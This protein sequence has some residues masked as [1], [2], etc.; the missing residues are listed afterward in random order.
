MTKIY[1]KTLLAKKNAG[2]TLIELLVVVLIIGI[3]S[4]VALPQY[5][6][7]VQKTRLMNYYQMAQGIRRAQEMYYLA[8][9]KYTTKLKDLDVDYSQTC[10][11]RENDGQVLDCPFA[12]IRNVTGGNPVPAANRVVIYFHPKGWQKNSQAIHSGKSLELRVYFQHSS[13]PNGVECEGATEEGTQL[14]A[15]LNLN[16]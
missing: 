1:Q 12:H 13:N 14:C 9:G 8:N 10:Y 7:A 5:Q 4:A 6:R 16:T 15:S 11:F 3:L 2:F